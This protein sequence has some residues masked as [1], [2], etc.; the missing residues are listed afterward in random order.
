M[1]EDVTLAGGVVLRQMTE[2]DAEALL[3]ACIRN[4][5]HLRRWEPR[6][7]ED[8]YTLAGQAIRLKGL[9]QQQARDQ[10]MPWAL[11]DGERIVG[12]VTLNDI[13]RGPFLNAQMG[14]WI[15]ADYTGRGLATQAALEVCRMADQDLGLHRI[16]AGTLLD[17]VASQ[18]VLRKAGFERFGTAPR[19]LEIDGRWQDHHLF[20]RILNDRPAF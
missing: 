15:D 10:A 7:P 3:A 9:L 20:Q 16:A 8:F 18:S 6:R 5:E 19:Y 13:V 1:I 14:Y 17:N 12:R 11:T 4:R 2:Q